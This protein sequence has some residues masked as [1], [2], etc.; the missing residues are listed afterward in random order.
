MRIVAP[1]N[2]PEEE[3]SVKSV[4]G[5]ARHHARMHARHVGE[6]SHL[7]CQAQKNGWLAQEGT[8]EADAKSWSTSTPEHLQ[9][10][11]GRE[12]YYTTGSQ[13]TT[14]TQTQKTCLVLVGRE[15]DTLDQKAK[16]LFC[17]ILA[18]L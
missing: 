4:S 6:A 2:T 13:F 9:P 10:K 15:R 11:E 3:S 16:P 5:P 1:Y 14:Q 12:I 7:K 8:Q 17:N 18:A